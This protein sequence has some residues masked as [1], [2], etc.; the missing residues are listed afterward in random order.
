MKSKRSEN[1]ERGGKGTNFMSESRVE[2]ELQ[3]KYHFTENQDMSVFL[4][5]PLRSC[6]QITLPLGFLICRNEAVRLNYL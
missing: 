3:G 1:V 5:L 2:S 4:A 6:G